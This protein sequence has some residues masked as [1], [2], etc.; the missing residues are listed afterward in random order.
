MRRLGS[1]ELARNWAIGVATAKRLRGGRFLLVN[2][3]PAGIAG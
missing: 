3:G 1:Y 2:L